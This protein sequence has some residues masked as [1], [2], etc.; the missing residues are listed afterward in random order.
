[1]PE[2]ARYVLPLVRAE[3]ARR[4]GTQTPVPVGG[5]GGG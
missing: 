2:Y 1:M 5:G 3:L 4:P